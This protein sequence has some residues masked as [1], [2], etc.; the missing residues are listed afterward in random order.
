MPFEVHVKYWMFL[1]FFLHT[2][3]PT[4]T[5]C[6][7]TFIMSIKIRLSFACECVCQSLGSCK[8]LGLNLS[9]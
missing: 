4:K 1:C 8:M 3:L 6:A 7:F 9:K 5:T 2:V